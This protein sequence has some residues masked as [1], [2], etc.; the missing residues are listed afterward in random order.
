[1]SRAGDDWKKA[2]ASRTSRGTDTVGSTKGFLLESSTDAGASVS[3][4]SLAEESS[5]EGVFSLLL[6]AFNLLTAVGDFNTAL[7]WG[8]SKKL[9]WRRRSNVEPGEAD[10]SSFQ[11]DG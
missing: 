8:A 9:T 10:S 5:V 4:F 11:P 7:A 2:V 6:K 3:C 1:M